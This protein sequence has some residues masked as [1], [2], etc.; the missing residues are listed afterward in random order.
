MHVRNLAVFHVQRPAA[1]LSALQVEFV[2]PIEIDVSGRIYRLGD[3]LEYHTEL[4]E[5]LHVQDRVNTYG[6]FY[7]ADLRQPDSRRAGDEHDHERLPATKDTVLP[8][9]V[10]DSR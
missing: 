10:T 3:L 5:R 4:A 1:K 6:S 7:I 9:A 8:H 2:D